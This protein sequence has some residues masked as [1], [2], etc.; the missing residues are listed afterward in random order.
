[1]TNGIKTTDGVNEETRRVCSWC[2]KTL[3][4]DETERCALCGGSMCGDCAYT[5]AK[6]GNRL[7][8]SC[9]K[10]CVGSCGK[11]YCP[12]HLLECCDCLRP[13]CEGCA[14]YCAWGGCVL[15]ETSVHMG[16]RDDFNYCADCYQG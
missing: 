9:K 5:C 13:V 15:C 14:A 2:D 10:E 1:M 8:E 11:A 16:D 6:C 12:S 4:A 7:C 3:R